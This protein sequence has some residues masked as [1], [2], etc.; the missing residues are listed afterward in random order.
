MLISTLDSKKNERYRDMRRNVVAVIMHLTGVFVLILPFFY[1]MTTDTDLDVL[2]NQFKAGVI[3][4][5]FMGAIGVI[6]SWLCMI[7]CDSTQ[8]DSEK[9]Q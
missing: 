9:K 1:C 6:V 3:L 2:E 7:G 5:M 8:E 4:C